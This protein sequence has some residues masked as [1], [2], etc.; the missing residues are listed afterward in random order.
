MRGTRCGTVLQAAGA[1][2]CG[3]RTCLAIALLI[4]TN[5]APYLQT[6]ARRRFVS[7]AG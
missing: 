1:V 5:F 7:A 3:P 2:D 4:A 6:A